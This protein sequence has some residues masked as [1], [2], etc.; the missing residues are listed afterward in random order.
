VTVQAY[1]NEQL[2]NPSFIVPNKKEWSRNN[3]HI[4]AVGE[5]GE[6]YIFEE[7]DNP[8][9]TAKLI[10]ELNQQGYTEKDFYV[11]GSN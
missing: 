10:D 4:A 9:R 6:L 2:K 3:G 7:N 8:A 5:D 11:P 1:E